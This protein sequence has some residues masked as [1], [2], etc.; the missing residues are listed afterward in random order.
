MGKKGAGLV[1]ARRVRPLNKAAEKTGGPVLY[2]CS[3]D[4]RVADNWA[5]IVCQHIPYGH[6]FFE[7]CT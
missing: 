1:D 3:R 4:Q 6:S 2:W 5:L 7:H